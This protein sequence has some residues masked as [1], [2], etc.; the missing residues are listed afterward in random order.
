MGDPFADKLQELKALSSAFYAPAIVLSAIELD[1]FTALGDQSSAEVG[2]MATTLGVDERA[3]GTLLGALVAQGFVERGDAV[4][5]RPTFRNT[6]FSAKA[7]R[8]GPDD[9]RDSARMSLWFMQQ[10]A[11]LADVVREG[12]PK[13]TFARAVAADPARG[14]SLTRAMDQVARGFVAELAQQLDLSRVHRILD[15]GGASGTFAMALVQGARAAGAV[16]AV[17]VVFDQ[18]G[19]RG[20]AEEIIAAR[21]LSSCV[22][23]RGGDFMSDALAH[24]RERF[25]LVF[26]SNVFHLLDE[27]AS[28]RLIARAAAVLAPAGRLVIKDMIGAPGGAVPKGLESYAV[29]MLLISQGGALHDEAH[30]RS[31]CAAAGLPATTRIDCWERSSLLIAARESA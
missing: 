29:L 22:S 6:A 23:F 10:A 18:E 8:A 30:Y 4:A 14:R 26:A 3:L 25:D 9:E 1:V 11:S 31:W 27:S 15:V 19:A 24:E 16:D 17:A 7:L 20:A 13:D 12:K 28:A 5:G 21:G 2:P